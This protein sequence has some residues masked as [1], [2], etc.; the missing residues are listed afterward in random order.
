MSPGTTFSNGGSSAVD[1]QLMGNPDVNKGIQQWVK[2][3]VTA[4]SRE[5]VTARAL[6]R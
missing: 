1:D 2:V 5:K 6:R 4:K 3:K